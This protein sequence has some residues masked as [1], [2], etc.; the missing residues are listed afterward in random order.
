[1]K[2][3]GTLCRHPKFN[4]TRLRGFREDADSVK[5]HADAS[6]YS[7]DPRKSLKQ[8]CETQG[9]TATYSFRKEDTLDDAASS[10][11]ICIVDVNYE[12]EDGRKL[13][14]VGKAEKKKDA[15]KQAALDVC[16]QLDER[17]L[18]LD[19]IKIS[20]KSK[21]KV[22]EFLKGEDDG[23]EYLDRTKTKQAETKEKKEDQKAETIE[24][25]SAKL[26]IV[27]S[28]LKS[29]DA[30]I[31]EKKQAGTRRLFLS[32]SLMYSQFRKKRKKKKRTNLI[33]LWLVSKRKWKQTRS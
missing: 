10:D 1:M 25:L 8:W 9:C 26:K 13:R 29:L 14:G 4:L 27:E 32:A 23:D 2:S 15:E 12:L 30:K 22:K 3:V 16:V 28:E 7:E 21:K 18:F 31:A 17:G 20:E 19:W 11:L 6:E 33:V 24:S 5:L